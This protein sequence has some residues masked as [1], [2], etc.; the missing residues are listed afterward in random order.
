MELHESSS[1]NQTNAGPDFE[2]FNELVEA[3]SAAAV[4]ALEIISDHG[5]SAMVIL[6]ALA[7]LA[8][9]GGGSWKATSWHGTIT[10]AISMLVT[11]VFGFAASW[12]IERRKYG[13]A[14][15]ENSDESAESGNEPAGPHTARET[16][17]SDVLRQFDRGHPERT[18]SV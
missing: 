11:A 13:K 7:A 16:Q 15:E 4:R 18:G 14:P 12:L 8:C 6:A 3:K 17:G 9:I 5:P 2:G 1:D 10:V